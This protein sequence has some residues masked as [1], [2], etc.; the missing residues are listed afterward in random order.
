VTISGTEYNLSSSTGSSI[1]PPPAGTC[2]GGQ[3][4]FG[5][6]SSTISVRISSTG[7]I[8][9]MSPNTGGPGGSVGFV[10]AGALTPTDVQAH[11]YS[12]FLFDSNGNRLP[13][14]LT[15]S[16][17]NGTGKPFADIDNNVLDTN[18]SDWGAVQLSTATSGVITGTTTGGSSTGTL[19]IVT[20]QANGRV[21]LFIAGEDARS[22]ADGGT[23]SSPYNLVFVSQ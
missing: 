5:S 17:G 2:V 19:K 11:G 14:S 20:G 16:G 10:Q 6:G 15:F 22:G 3:A 12:G 1:S 9:A 18:P 23:S 21:F 13:Y 4:L 8:L 7:A